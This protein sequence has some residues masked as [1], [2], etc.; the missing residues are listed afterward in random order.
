MERRRFLTAGVLGGFGAWIGPGR[1]LDGGGDAEPGAVRADDEEYIDHVRR[2]GLFGLLRTV[3][4]VGWIAMTLRSAPGAVLEVRLSDFDVDPE[5]EDLRLTCAVTGRWLSIE[6]C[7]AVPYGVGLYYWKSSPD[8]GLVPS[9][10]FDA[11]AHVEVYL[12]QTEWGNTM[13]LITSPSP[14]ATDAAG[15]ASRRP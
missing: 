11:P 7:G 4:N 9:V 3:P 10:S 13:V 8:D 6:I 2:S 14:G 12:R 5:R 1:A 15:G